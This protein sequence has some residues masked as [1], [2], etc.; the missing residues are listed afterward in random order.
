[1]DALPR[2]DGHSSC[3]E[4]VRYLEYLEAK[5]MAAW[6]NIAWMNVMNVLPILH[7]LGWML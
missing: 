4:C 3:Q 5:A 6:F 1:M 2:Y 7:A